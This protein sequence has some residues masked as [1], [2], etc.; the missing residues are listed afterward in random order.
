MARRTVALYQDLETGRTQYI[1]IESIYTVVGGKQ[2]NIPDKINDLRNKSRSRELFCPCGCG[3]NLILVAGDKNLREQHFRIRDDGNVHKCHVVEE[4]DVSIESKVVLKCW[5]D[6]KLDHPDIRTRVAIRDVDDSDR[7]YEFS[8]LSPEKKIALNYS[9][10]RENLSEEKIRILESNKQQYRVFYVV[11]ISNGGCDGQY[12][13]W[14]MKIQQVQGYC[15]LLKIDGIE[16]DRASMAAVYYFRDPDGSWKEQKICEGPLKEYWIDGNR[17][18]LFQSRLIEEMKS[19]IEESLRIARE[20][21]LR[22]RAK[23]ARREKQEQERIQAQIREKEEERR[24]QQEVYRQEQIRRA[25]EIN[26]RRRAAEAKRRREEELR[27]EQKKRQKEMFAKQLEELLSQ[28]ET[29]VRDAE[30]NRWIKCEY[31]GK[32]AM[33][34]K[35]SSYGGPGRVNLGTCRECADHDPAASRPAMPAFRKRNSGSGASGCPYCGGELL[36]KNG[37]FGPFVGC[38][39]YPRCRFTRRM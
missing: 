1:G 10:K 8:F 27:L 35:F 2:I 17:N 39:N 25:E 4:G 11:D 23:K 38:S 36:E 13:E 19:G 32:I 37:R 22:W 3:S 15:L 29:Q 7:K 12:P 14:L 20:R 6:E 5:L 9:H 16:Y 18:L 33:E 21:L 24:R 28:Q 26:A 31:C 30:G 34:N